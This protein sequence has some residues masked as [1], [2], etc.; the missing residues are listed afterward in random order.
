MIKC[1]PM[2]FGERLALLISL[3]ALTAL[4]ERARGAP[5]ETQVASAELERCA[6]CHPREVKGFLKTGMGRSLEPARGAEVIER[7]NWV[8]VEGRQRVARVQHPKSG[9]EYEA[10]IDAEGRWWQTERHLG[11]ERRVEVR[12]IIGS[13]AHTRSYLGERDGALVELPLT[14][15]SERG[16]W[17]MSPGYEEAD[18][19]RFDRLIS[20]ECLFCHTDL[21]ATPQAEEALRPISCQRCH[22]DGTQHVEAHLTGEGETAIFNPATL[23]PT[24]RAQLCEQ[25]HLS[26]ATRVLL[27]GQRWS[28]HQP[29]R[30]LESLMVVYGY[31]ELTRIGQPA[32]PS[33]FERFGVASH[34]E[35][36]KLSA[37]AQG[38]Q[39]LTCARCH[40][41]HQPSTPERYQATCL[42]CHQADRA[43][44]HPPVSKGEAPRPYKALEGCVRCHMKRGAT[45]DIPH[46]SYTDHWIRAR[47]RE[48]APEG[49]APDQGAWRLQALTEPPR[50]PL[51]AELSLLT[52]LSQ[53]ALYGERPGG[54]ILAQRAW[55][56]LLKRLKEA[57]ESPYR[58]LLFRS[59]VLLVK[60]G[61]NVSKELLESDSF[62][63]YLSRQPR[64]TLIISR[65][66][67]QLALRSEEG[68]ERS[69]LTGLS[70]RLLRA[71]LARSPAA[72][73]ERIEQQVALADLLQL[74]GSQLEAEQRYLAANK[75][76]RDDLSGP[77]NLSALYLSQGRWSEARR[78]IDE[79]IKRDPISAQPR[80]RE[81]LWF[82][83][84]GELA[85]A[86]SAAQR[87]LERALSTLE[88]GE[89]LTLSLE[90]ADAR[91][92][93]T[94]AEELLRGLISLEPD[95]VHHHERLAE[96]LWRLKRPHD[97]LEVLQTAA[98]HFKSEGLASRAKRLKLHLEGTTA[99][100]D[101]EHEPPQVRTP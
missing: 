54:A 16:I 50:A 27:P 87:A 61:L 22:G 39:A 99:V 17:D 82:L 71:Q 55:A 3:T 97:A 92:E 21:S 52:A 78:W 83:A 40:D 81:A 6:D 47:A 88:R 64:E 37:C 70:A 29:Q 73:L 93:L 34:A 75:V 33:A 90:L 35:R 30:A 72:R 89:C 28:E 18:H 44:L 94:R 96:L 7:F 38:G 65:W 66:V 86:S 4:S 31:E 13:G 63:Q 85:Q 59:Y 10:S 49:Q 11:A 32:Y 43:S 101:E 46:V 26:G 58:E 24:R 42:S 60:M 67:T 23:S 84:R 62:V 19:D 12:Y 95:A 36:L 68:A 79:S 53:V 74:T 77:L 9:V 25:C 2:T 1:L 15:Y 100:R 45:S 5:R 20:T 57:L 41:P 56:Q 14:W 91:G 69:W 48:G 8:G 98:E 76:S 80:Y 51:G